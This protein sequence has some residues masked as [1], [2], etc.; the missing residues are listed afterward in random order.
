L[1]LKDEFFDRIRTQKEKNMI[2]DIIANFKKKIMNTPIKDTKIKNIKSKIDKNKNMINDFT[3]KIKEDIKKEKEQPN[4]YS[5]FEVDNLIDLQNKYIGIKKKYIEKNNNFIF[6]KLKKKK[7]E[8]NNKINKLMFEDVIIEET[9]EYKELEKIKKELEK[10][11]ISEPNTIKYKKLIFEL[12]EIEKEFEKRYNHPD[13]VNFLN[14]LSGNTQNINPLEYKTEYNNDY[15]NLIK[16]KENLSE[17][18][19]NAYHEQK[20]EI[21]DELTNKY[22]IIESKIK[23]LKP[24]KE[25]KKELKPIEE[26]KKNKKKPKIIKDD[27]FIKFKENFNKNINKISIANHE[28]YINKITEE[29]YMTENEK[30]KLFKNSKKKEKDE[31]LKFLYKSYLNFKDNDERYINFLKDQYTKINN[32]K[33][34]TFNNFII[35]MKEYKE[36]P[37]I[38]EELKIKEEKKIKIKKDKKE[39]KIKTHHSPDI[40]IKLKKKAY[41]LGATD[42]GFSGE[43]DKRFYVI[44]DDK[45]INF[46][47]KDGDTFIDHNDE[48]IMKA[49]KAR[50]SKIKNKKGEYVYKLKSSPDYW[51]WNLLWD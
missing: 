44:Y 23:E 4:K 28:I 45:L 15:D 17:L 39:P 47:S 11:S 20:F 46:G 38:K 27:S 6:N 40:I 48:D 42:F 43:K 19:N 2:W 3:F 14:M 50:H 12:L 18:I 16:E 35:N 8:L 30:N 36:E 31:Q 34:I 9:K 25:E 51:S 5:N 32:N 33:N 21:L 49:W 1:T 13:F 26:E 37:E 24:T 10:K 29:N 41:E 22:N 7:D